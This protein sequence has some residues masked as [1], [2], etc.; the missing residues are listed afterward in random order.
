MKSILRIALAVLGL[1][2]FAISDGHATC[3]NVTNGTPQTFTTLTQS[4]FQNGQGAGALTYGCMRDL[5]ASTYGSANN[6]INL[7]NLGLPTGGDDTVA[8][9]AAIAS[10]LPASFTGT[11]SMAVTI[12]ANPN[13]VGVLTVTG[14]PGGTVG[15]GQSVTGTPATFAATGSIGASI[16]GTS[17]YGAVMNITAASGTLALGQYITG[18]GIP[19]GEYITG[20]GTGTGG[21]GTYFV[22][23]PQ[24]IASEAL[25]IHPTIPPGTVIESQISG[26]A[27]GAGTYS[28]SAPVTIPSTTLTFQP[29]ATANVY[30]PCGLYKHAG[31]INNTGVVLYGDGACTIFQSTDAAGTGC[32]GSGPCLAMYLYGVGGGYRNFA[33][34]S[35]YSST[36][37]RQNTG[38]QQAISITNASQF[39]I[40]GIRV[41]GSGAGAILNSGGTRFVEHD[42]YVG[43]TIADG[44]H[45][46]CG[47]AYGSI[48][49]NL[50]ENNGDDAFPVVSYNGGPFV[51]DIKLF[52]NTAKGSTGRNFVVDGGYNIVF[53]DSTADGGLSC[54]FFEGG[55]SYAEKAFNITAS[56]ITCT[57]VGSH[58]GIIQSPIMLFGNL[59]TFPGTLDNVDIHD[60]TITQAD[61]HCAT[62]GSAQGASYVS[63][64]KYHHNTCNGLADTQSDLLIGLQ[65]VTNIDITDNNFTNWGW[66]GIVSVPANGNSGRLKISGNTFNNINTENNGGARVVDSQAD[67]W[68]S[69]VIKDNYLVNGLHAPAAYFLITSCGQCEIDGNISASGASGPAQT[70]SGVTYGYFNNPYST[71]LNTNAPQIQGGT[72]FTASGCSNGTTVGSGTAGKFTLG[73]VSCSVVVTMN[74]AT[75]MTATNGWACAPQD[76]TH[77]TALIVQSAN[78]TT[79]ATFAVPGSPAAIS[80]VVAFACQ[81]Y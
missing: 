60:T 38:D 9:N 20:L 18:T 1:A 47:A 4:E 40:A 8:I 37:L 2:V 59:T 33:I 19:D 78:T 81:P 69:M 57:N 52:G 34:T 16:L 66:G 49:G 77:P 67:S 68:T 55:G 5:I 70:V 71:N 45:T 7:K 17:G 29:K 75:G 25:V 63:N 54:L 56:G 35:T 64:V 65:G 79:T 30:A 74:G 23:V 28:L 26:T 58:A 3:T 21:T 31:I 41:Y 13:T 11:G 80:D 12:T 32:L 51:H 10:A 50:V 72:K 24:T 15:I 61:L 46:C 53:A 6:N 73:A 14:T 36:S 44:I 22:S 42:N 39:E 62:I 76:Q 48:Y 27:G 43:S